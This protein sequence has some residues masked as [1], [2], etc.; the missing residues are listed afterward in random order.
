[1]KS[2]EPNR[3][4]ADEETLDRLVDDELTEVERANLLRQF[5]SQ[6]DGWRRCALAFLEAQA[7]RRTFSTMV[8]ESVSTTIP[9]PTTRLASRPMGKLARRTATVLAMAASFVA[10]LW[11]GW[12]VQDL[13]RTIRVPGAGPGEVASSSPKP[14]GA[15]NALAQSVPENVEPVVPQGWAPQRPVAPNSPWQMVT[16]SADGQNGEGSSTIRLPACEKPC[17]DS[18]WPESLPSAMPGDVL[19]SLR[20]TGY[21]VHQHKELL[22]IEMID[23]RRLVVPVEKVDVQYP[24]Q[25]PL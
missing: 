3:N 12:V 5:D 24:R 8:D 4:H 6:P 19:E 9:K 16:L 21:E 20:R 10:A 22:P 13:D 1:M 14:S 17:L 2:M 7:W 25:P 18:R 15:P 23:G 11:L